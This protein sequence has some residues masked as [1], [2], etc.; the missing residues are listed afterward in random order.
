MRR[1]CRSHG[2]RSAVP[3]LHLRPTPDTASASFAISSHKSSVVL[4]NLHSHP[5]AS[6]ATSRCP[7]SPRAID[8]RALARVTHGHEQLCH[9]ERSLQAWLADDQPFPLRLADRVFLLRP[10][11]ALRNASSQRRKKP[12]AP[13]LFPPAA[14]EQWL[15][16]TNVW[17]GVTSPHGS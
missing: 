5:A 3:P 9:P 17:R 4:W 13:I 15:R 10:A 1:T 11:H 8:T 7:L 2:A 12:W 6:A 14:P 16:Q